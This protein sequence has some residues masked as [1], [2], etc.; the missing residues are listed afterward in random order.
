MPRYKLHDIRQATTYTSNWGFFVIRPIADRMLWVIANYIRVTP[1][2]LTIVSFLITLLS[3]WCFYK[4]M[5]IYLIAGA[6]L[7]ELAYAIDC[8][9]GGLARLK[10]MESKL[11]AYM[12]DMTAYWGIF[13]VIL[14]LAYGQFSL[15]GNTTYLLLGFTY[16]FIHLLAWL[17]YF[18]LQKSGIDTGTSVFDSVV[19][20][21]S[22]VGRTRA[23]L[24]SKNILIGVPVTDVDAL[25]LFIFP[26]L[27]QVKLG[28]II[29]SVIIFATFVVSWSLLLSRRHSK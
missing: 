9:D 28:L 29:G 16:I 8:V 1:N 23:W 22:L 17:E 24:T 20:P 10:G 5:P 3:A 18:V 7:F 13:L 15:T 2:Q 26:L 19:K 12:D 21:G 4:G 6:L 27:N 11:G 14:G 25:V